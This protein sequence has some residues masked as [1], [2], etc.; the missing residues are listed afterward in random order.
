MLTLHEMV[1][2]FLCKHMPWHFLSTTQ[3]V[4]DR[5]PDVKDIFSRKLFFK[6]HFFLKIY[7]ALLYGL[8]TSL[9]N[10]S[11]KNKRSTFMNWIWMN[12]N[13]GIQTEDVIKM[14]IICL[15]A[16]LCIFV[17]CVAH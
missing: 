8:M 16:K 1:T 3:D 15:F 11:K 17:Q 7:F 2:R 9:M 12:L 14:I 4:S 13:Q 10:L 6:P 5:H